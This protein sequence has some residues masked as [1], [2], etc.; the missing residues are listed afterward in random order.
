M[1]ASPVKES[2]S[3]RR[4]VEHP[5]AN[6]PESSTPPVQASVA[7]V[8]PCVSIII[9]CYNAEPF[10]DQTIEA[11]TRQ[12]MTQWECIIVDDRSSDGSAAIAAQWAARDARIQVIRKPANEGVSK[13]RN[14]GLAA[15][16]ER[17]EYVMFLDADDLLL[18]DALARLLER[19]RLAPDAV[20]ACGGVVVITSK[21]ERIASQEVEKRKELAVRCE[22]GRLLRVDDPSCIGFES[23][24]LQN[25][26]IA[27][28][29]VLLRKGPAKAASVGG[30]L[31][32][33]WIGLCEDWDVWLRLS[34]Q[35]RFVYVAEATLAYRR[36]GGNLSANIGRMARSGWR[37]RWKTYRS[38]QNTPSQ[39]V[40]VR[41]AYRAWHR[42]T[43]RER[44][45]LA[46]AAL[47]ERRYRES[48]R[49]AVPTLWT[50]MHG[51]LW[52]LMP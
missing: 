35:G 42:S 25:I 37:F 6:A 15:V 28:G 40:Y 2:G 21:G 16:G 13:T 31:F 41:N 4:Q 9:P 17:T 38:P 8:E 43:F 26:M 20:G 12:S 33:P 5:M 45:R 50:G 32:D 39:R 27:P 52:L 19:L 3:R 36:H 23:L 46:L 29:S 34:R 48:F 18:P 14:V 47:R 44:C 7:G 1:G 22:G 11:L 51:L 30:E 10:L 49:L 24:V